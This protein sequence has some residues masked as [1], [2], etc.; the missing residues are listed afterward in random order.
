MSI[1]TSRSK[2]FRKILSVLF[3]CLSLTFVHSSAVDKS[4]S[5]FECLTTPNG[6]PRKVIVKKL[7]VAAYERPDF[8]GSKNPYLYDRSRI[9]DV[10]GLE[11]NS[12]GRNSHNG[13]ID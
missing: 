2:S 6:I 11:N 10:V 4:T 1:F 12:Y 8:T 3:A 9:P 5:D 13:I 7:D